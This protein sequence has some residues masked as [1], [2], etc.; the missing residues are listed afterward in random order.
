MFL[1]GYLQIVAM[2]RCRVGRCVDE[3]KVT[4]LQEH[5]LR[6]VEIIGEENLFFVCFPA[7]HWKM[8][9]SVIGQRRER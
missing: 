6:N 2:V 9:P 5:N 4:S 3:E 1:R 7:F 8:K